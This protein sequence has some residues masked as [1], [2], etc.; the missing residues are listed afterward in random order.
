[1]CEVIRLYCGLGCG[2]IGA[3]TGNNSGVPRHLSSNL[4]GG[5]MLRGTS[6]VPV[7]PTQ[8]GKGTQGQSLSCILVG[9]VCIWCCSSLRCSWQLYCIGRVRFWAPSLN[10]RLR[11]RMSYWG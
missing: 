11:D 5:L 9:L 6:G 4:G 2:L 10:Q 1:M 8:G 7:L 3:A